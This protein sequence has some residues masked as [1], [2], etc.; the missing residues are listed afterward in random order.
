MHGLAVVGDQ[1]DE[2]GGG[3]R[4]G[5]WALVAGAAAEP[6]EP[7]PDPAQAARSS[8]AS[9]ARARP[10]VLRWW[11]LGSMA[12]TCYLICWVKLAV[13]GGPSWG[14]A[15]MVKVVDPA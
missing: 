11:G 8:A 2:L 15:L 4:P 1:D 12:S 7:S 14:V 10:T 9:Q 13:M 6:E 3:G 5:R